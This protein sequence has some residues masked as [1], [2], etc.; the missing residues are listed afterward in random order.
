MQFQFLQQICDKQIQS[1][2]PA[3]DSGHIV[4]AILMTS[5]KMCGLFI[6]STLNKES[7]RSSEP[8][9]EVCKTSLSSGSFD[10]QHTFFSH[11]R[12]EPM[13]GTPGL[14]VWLLFAMFGS[15]HTAF[16][17]SKFQLAFE[18]FQILHIWPWQFHIHELAPIP[19]C[20]N[21]YSTLISLWTSQRSGQK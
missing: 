21:S 9:R 20:W 8:G 2:H 17:Q 14:P 10:I 18:D 6:L 3:F 19:R 5:G 4:T 7:H 1:F 11:T 13:R 15:V 16:F 12:A